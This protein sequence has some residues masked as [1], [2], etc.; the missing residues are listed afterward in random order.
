MARTFT[1]N[2]ANYISMGTGTI[3]TILNGAAAVS[4][5]ANVNFTSFDAG[6]SATGDQFLYIPINGTSTGIVGCIDGSGGGSNQKFKVGGR[7][8]AAD[9]FQ[10]RSGTTNLTTGVWYPLGGVIDYSADTIT[11]YLSGA[12]ENGGAATFGATSYTHGTP[13]TTDKLSNAASTAQMLDGV[14]CEVG[15]WNVALTAGEML[16]LGKG[17]SPLLVRPSSLIFYMPLMGRVSPEPD[18]VRGNNGTVNGTLAQA[19]HARVIYPD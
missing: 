6:D 11:G 17:F 10:A 3:G 18:R 16:A 15:I 5:H 13:S 7:S 9:S 14:L 8:Q 12:A 1:K 2:T 4:F 19:D